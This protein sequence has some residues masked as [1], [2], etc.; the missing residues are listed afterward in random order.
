MIIPANDQVQANDHVQHANDH[1]QAND[2]DQQA[3]DLDRTG[4]TGK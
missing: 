1:V 4:S 2:H 3:N